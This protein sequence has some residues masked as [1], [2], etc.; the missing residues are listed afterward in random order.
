MIFSDL[1]WTLH[2]CAR[3]CI[4]KKVLRDMLAALIFLVGAE[5]LKNSSWIFGKCWVWHN[6]ILLLVML[7]WN[8]VIHSH[9]L[10][11][12]TESIFCVRHCA[13]VLFTWRA[14]SQIWCD[15][16]VC[17]YFFGGVQTE[18]LITFTLSMNTVCRLVL[19]NISVFLIFQDSI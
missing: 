14:V 1:P 12:F 4:S 9:I 6:C 17:G 15:S 8:E 3:L 18:R 19:C 16:K 11:V 13:S 7:L 10:H 2:F 5:C